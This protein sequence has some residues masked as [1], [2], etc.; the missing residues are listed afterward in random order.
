IGGTFATWPLL[1]ALARTHS[2]TT[3]FLLLTLALM[4]VSGYTS[5][6]SVMKAELFPARLRALGVGVPYAIATAIFGGTAGY[7]GLWF[8]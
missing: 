7:V 3:A 6:C 5:V 8:K 1:T 4:I 2:A